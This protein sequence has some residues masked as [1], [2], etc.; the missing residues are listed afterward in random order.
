[1]MQI[2]TAQQQEFQDL[3][4]DKLI[5]LILIDEL[6]TLI[7]Q[8][9]NKPIEITIDPEEHVLKYRTLLKKRFKTMEGEVLAKIKNPPKDVYHSTK[10]R[11]T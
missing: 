11:W 1:M 2:Q 4:A 10:Q 6:P 7:I 8:A 9:Q 5:E 3:V